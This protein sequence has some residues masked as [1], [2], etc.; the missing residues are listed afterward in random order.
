LDK[1]LIPY[2]STQKPQSSG[3]ASSSLIT[4]RQRENT[5][6]ELELD[7]ISVSFGSNNIELKIVDGAAALSYIFSVAEPPTGA[8]WN[9][10]WFPL[11]LIFSRCI[12]LAFVT[13]AQTQT[14]KISG[15]PIM[16]NVVY[17]ASPGVSSSV[18]S[19][20]FMFG[21]ALPSQPYD[22]IDSDIGKL[23]G[24]ARDRATQWRRTEILTS[25][26]KLQ[27]ATAV[28]PL[29]DLDKLALCER[30]HFLF[31]EV[32]RLDK[33]TVD[34]TF[35][36]LYKH[37]D[38]L[39]NSTF[40]RVDKK[41]WMRVQPK[42][43][44]TRKDTKPALLSKL[45]KLI[46]CRNQ[47][48]GSPGSVEADTTIAALIEDL[49]VFNVTPHIYSKK[50]PDQ[51]QGALLLQSEVTAKAR[52]IVADWWL[53]GDNQASVYAKLEFFVDTFDKDDHSQSKGRYGQCAETYP[54]VGVG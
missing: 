17:L 35:P 40:E 44:L 34:I 18:S 2:R 11:C 1:K 9:T 53:A 48:A 25:E 5:D 37:A 52:R 47:V 50:L 27:S 21:A 3:K 15:V 33:D 20:P 36:D 4:I 14:E 42:T 32:R 39:R 13:D 6:G 54:I 46:D 29:N 23:R 41:S 8:D 49:L 30:L 7:P 24:Q 12:Y 31:T 16:A 51:T 43:F 45:Q 38:N 22:D 28:L 26:L 10:Y 19:R